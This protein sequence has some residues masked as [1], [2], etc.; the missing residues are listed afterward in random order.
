MSELELSRPI[1]TRSLPAEPV[2]VEANTSERAALAS[3]FGLEAIAKLSATVDL[4]GGSKAIRATGTLT[5]EITQHCAVSGEPF[6]V[7]VR[8]TILLKFIE[9]DRKPNADNEDDEIEIEIELE[10]DDCDEIDYAG[11]TFDLGE[12][13]AQTLGLAIDPYAVG[14]DAEA[15]RISAGIATEGEQDGPLA[16]ALAALKKD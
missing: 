6:A 14:P 2:L 1:K 12:A 15:A 3:R 8:E 4:E 16:A 10:A 5:A 7:T 9:S 13:I 11:D